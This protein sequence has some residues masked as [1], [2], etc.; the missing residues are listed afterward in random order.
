[1]THSRDADVASR[2]PSPS[3]SLE[4]DMLKTGTLKYFAFA[5]ILVGVTIGAIT[6][7]TPVQA[8]EPCLDCPPPENFC[9]GC[10]SSSGS[11][12]HCCGGTCTSSPCTP[13]GIQP[14]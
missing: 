14:L 7:L 11:D 6:A 13:S 10:G 8:D 2:F 9:A 1:M 12:K 5:G 4:F 3:N